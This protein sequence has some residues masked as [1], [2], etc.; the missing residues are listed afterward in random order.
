MT[1]LFLV[2]IASSVT[3]RRDVYSCIQMLLLLLKSFDVE[4]FINDKLEIVLHL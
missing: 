3:F 1:T 2:A 4:L